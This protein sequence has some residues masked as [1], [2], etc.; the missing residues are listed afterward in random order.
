[1]TKPQQ[2]LVAE[3][4]TDDRSAADMMAG[5]APGT[6]PGIR[7]DQLDLSQF[8]EPAKPAAKSSKQQ[9]REAVASVFRTAEVAFNQFDEPYIILRQGAAVRLIPLE[10]QDAVDWL[11]LQVLRQRAETLSEDA[12]KA[13]LGLIRAQAKEVRR[14]IRMYKRTARL[15]AAQAVAL[16]IDPATLFV[17]LGTPTGEVVVIGGGCWSVQPNPGVFFSRGPGYGE[18]PLPLSAGGPC[19]ALKVMVDWGVASGLTEKAAKVLTAMV[20]YAMIPRLSKPIIEF[21]GPPGAS[22]S[23]KTQQAVQ[24]IDPTTTQFAPE[25]PIKDEHIAAAAR[26]HIVLVADN[27]NGLSGAQSDLLCRSCSGT[28]I[29]FRKLYFQGAMHTTEVQVT[30]ILNGV[31]SVLLRADLRNRA[32]TFRLPARTKFQTA[33]EVEREFTQQRPQL[34]GALFDLLAAGLNTMPQVPAIDLQLRLADLARFGE[35]MLIACGEPAGTFV[36]LLHSFQRSSSQDMLTEDPFTSKVLEALR[37][38]TK[39]P[40]TIRSHEPPLRDWIKGSGKAGWTAYKG[41]DG[42]TTVCI[43]SRHMLSRLRSATLYRNE[44]WL[45]DDE[46]KLNNALHQATPAFRDVGIDAAQEKFGDNTGWRFTWMPPVAG[47][48]LSEEP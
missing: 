5:P 24:L 20:A 15:D 16:G 31:N 21:I 25:V 33:E 12:A 47:L 27:Q 43:G 29:S 48:D 18:H 9:L 13:E 17:D 41:Q 30:I 4:T 10:S 2:P 11:R 39:P 19:A 6:S 22:K 46:R 23:T 3:P 38:C 37:D 40:S 34:L 8:T 1:M 42:R 28:S 35:A 32:C 26:V 44:G 36:E 7:L 45:P 14:Q